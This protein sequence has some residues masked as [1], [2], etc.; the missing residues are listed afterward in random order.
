MAERR[1][2]SEHDA[3]RLIPK[4]F[5]DNTAI[6]ASV[7]L[8]PTAGQWRSAQFHYSVVDDGCGRS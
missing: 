6:I 5:C 8:F 3:K 1:E 2:R 7:R 4:V